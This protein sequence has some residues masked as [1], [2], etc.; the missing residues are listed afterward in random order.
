MSEMRI[1]ETTRVG[2]NGTSAL[3]ARFRMFSSIRI[4]KIGAPSLCRLK[5]LQCET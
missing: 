3:F 1:V 4:L 5:Q 2:R